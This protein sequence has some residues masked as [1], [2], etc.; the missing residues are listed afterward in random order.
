MSERLRIADED[1]ETLV[2]LVHRHLS[3]VHLAFRRDTSEPEGILEFSREVGSAERLRMLFALSAA[4]LMGVGPGIWTQWKSQLL[5]DLFD[6]ML[7]LLTGQDAAVDHAL[8]LAEIKQRVLASCVAGPIHRKTTR[9][10]KANWNPARTLSLAL[11][12]D[13]AAGADCRRPRRAAELSS[14]QAGRRRSF[15][16][17]EAAPSSIT[18]SSPTTAT[19]PAVFTRRPVC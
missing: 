2:F 6:R 3:M 1:R 13:H 18:A 5:F 11:S 17:A 8:R 4:D 16:S 7:L 14:R 15:R 12:H 9:S 19:W 10:T